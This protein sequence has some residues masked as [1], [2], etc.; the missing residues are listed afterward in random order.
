M[1]VLEALENW[2]GLDGA[3]KSLQGL[4]AKALR[5]QRLRGMLSGRLLGHP[6][7]PMLTDLPIGCWLSVTLLDLVALAPV[8]SRR[9]LGTGIIAAVPTAVS[10][11]SDWIDTEDAEQRVGLVHA[12]GNLIGLTCMTV[13]WCR[14]RQGGSGKA[15]ALVGL[16]AMSVSGWL[17][18]HLSF[19]M[20][21]GVD[22]NAFTSGPQEWSAASLTAQG[23]HGLARYESEEFPLVVAAVGE[24]RFALADRCSHRGG[25]LS[26]GGLEGG[27][28]VC[29]WHGSRFAAT[30]GS[31]R[32]GPA[33]IPQPTY[34]LRETGSSVEVRRKEARALR[35]N[36]A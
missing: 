18:G 7:H 27:C 29:P 28:I 35:R 32:A 16:G 11:I 31:V 5:N 25:P 8:A 20:G 4:S 14:R 21:V 10:G 15:L 3:S 9:L 19:A 24:Q 1:K 17:G 33:S 36:P 6:L 2:A 13:S 34:E 26:D 23:A 30:D 12:C 22:T